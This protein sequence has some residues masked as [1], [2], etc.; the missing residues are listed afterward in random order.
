MMKDGEEG[1]IRKKEIINLSILKQRNRIML[2]GY[3]IY[4]N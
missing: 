4:W 1:K 2:H 3:K